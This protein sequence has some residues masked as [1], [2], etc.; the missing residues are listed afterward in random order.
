MK[1]TLKDIEYVIKKET[2]YNINTKK[3]Q[4]HLV[5]LRKIFFFIARKHTDLSLSSMG[6]FLNR[7]HATSLHNINSAKNLIEF[8]PTFKR[9]L[10]KLEEMVLIKCSNEYKKQFI[11]KPRV[12]HP[13][14]LRY[15]KQPLRKVLNKRR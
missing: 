3:R 11:I 15:A 7:D 13:A 6:K 2:G 8:E 12:I 14:L 9:K 4:R 10:F 5:D 1:V